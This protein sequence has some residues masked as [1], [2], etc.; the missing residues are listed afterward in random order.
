MSRLVVDT[1]SLLFSAYPVEVST[2][3]CGYRFSMGVIHYVYQQKYL[4]SMQN[5]YSDLQAMSLQKLL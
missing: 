4:L 2:T 1:N 5:N 3:T